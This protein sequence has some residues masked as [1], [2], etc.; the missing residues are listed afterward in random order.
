MLSND[1]LEHLSN[2][3]IRTINTNTLKEITEISI[4]KDATIEE[5]IEQFFGYIENPYCFLVGG[6][7]VQ[8]A[9]N[10]HNYTLDKRLY[11]YMKDKENLDI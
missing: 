1:D 9:Y 4:D 3:D 11:N 6:T 5:K 10:D 7:P 8:I 2:I